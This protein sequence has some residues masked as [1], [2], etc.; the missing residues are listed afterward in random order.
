MYHDVDGRTEGKE[1]EGF[2]W[3]SME[4]AKNPSECGILDLPELVHQGLLRGVFPEPELAAIGN[5]RDNAGLVQEM[6]VG[7]GHPSDQITK[8]G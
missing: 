1:D 4:G 5:D 6:E 7:Q 2:S 3:G 8:A